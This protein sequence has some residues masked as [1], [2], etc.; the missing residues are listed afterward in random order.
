MRVELTRALGVL[1]HEL[2]GSVGIVQGYIRL[3][4]L[5]RTDEQEER[6]L[7][8][9]MEATARLAALGAQ[10]SELAHW[11]E[12]P[13]GGEV[14]TIR[15]R[16]WL[17][18]AARA[19]DV[20]AGVDIRCG[21]EAGE[22]GVQ[23]HDMAALTAA[24]ATTLQAAARQ[25]PG[26]P[27]VVH[28]QEPA[29]DSAATISIGASD[30]AGAAPMDVSGRPGYPEF[31]GAKQFGFDQGGHGLA[32]VLASWVLAA[33]GARVESQAGEPGPVTLNIPITGA[34]Q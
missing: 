26:A 4:R 31:S 21:A 8:A 1:A 23:S 6:M 13:T 16:D 28:A 20:P 34:H 17:D 32:L 29:A 27:V 24:L 15:L 33:H 25:R 2:R 12:A 11:Q 22:W 3:L 19:A 5:R 9:M 18:R 10:A 30:S 7:Q 14:V